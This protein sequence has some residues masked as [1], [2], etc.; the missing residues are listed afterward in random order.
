MAPAAITHT[1]SLDT[2]SNCG[3][4]LVTQP[5]CPPPPPPPLPS[6]PTNVTHDTHDTHATCHPHR[7]HHEPAI[8]IN[9]S[10]VHEMALLLP[11]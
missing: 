2:H 6:L 9:P 8:P 11:Q 3:V 10:Y 4:Q 1:Q 5:K 7:P